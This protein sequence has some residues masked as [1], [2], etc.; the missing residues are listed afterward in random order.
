VRVDMED[1]EMGGIGVHGI[2]FTNNK[3]FNIY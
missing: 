3:K 1:G 2:K